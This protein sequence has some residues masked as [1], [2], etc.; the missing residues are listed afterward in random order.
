MSNNNDLTSFSRESLASRMEDYVSQGRKLTTKLHT[1]TLTN[2]D[3]F[4]QTDSVVENIDKNVKKIQKILED[5]NKSFTTSFIQN[6][7]NMPSTINQITPEL[8]S[9]RNLILQMNQIQQLF[10]IPKHMKIWQ[11]KG[12]YEKLIETLQ[13][14]T[15]IVK[16]F[17]E[18]PFIIKLVRECNTIALKLNSSLLLS[19]RNPGRI[20]SSSQ[21]ITHT[22]KV[23]TALWKLNLA[24]DGIIQDA[25]LSGITSSMSA[26]LISLMKIETSRQRDS[27]PT[28]LSSLIASFTSVSI[29]ISSLFQSFSTYMNDSTAQFRALFMNAVLLKDIEKTRNEQ[30]MHSLVSTILQTLNSSSSLVLSSKDKDVE[31]E[32]ER[33][34]NRFFESHPATDPVKIILFYILSSVVLSSFTGHSSFVESNA[35]KN[36]SSNLTPPNPLSSSAS[37]SSSI[38]YIPFDPSRLHFEVPL[39]LP[40]YAALDSSSSSSSSSSNSSSSIFDEVCS[41]LIPSSTTASHSDYLLHTHFNCIFLNPSSSKSF[42]SNKSI[43]L[44]SPSSL[45]QSSHYSLLFGDFAVNR[46]CSEWLLRQERIV[47]KAVAAAN[48]QYGRPSSGANSLSSTTPLSLPISTLFPQKQTIPFLS[49]NAAKAEQLYKEVTMLL[50]EYDL[51]SNKMGFSAT[52]ALN[53]NKDTALTHSTRLPSHFSAN[54]VLQ[55]WQQSQTNQLSNIICAIFAS[56]L[57]YSLRSDMHH[58]TFYQKGLHS[59]LTI[60]F[61]ADCAKY[62]NDYSLYLLNQNSETNTKPAESKN[63]DDNKTQLS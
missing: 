27:N 40:S 8:H 7:S 59:S 42:L 32:L 45:S 60:C 57:P 53:Q 31:K 13:G 28:R 30:N 47:R 22:L 38:D 12:E 41:D 19:L 24:S 20:T 52:Q 49:T 35:Q 17:P 3:L 18:S 6:L 9:T 37:S 62:L 5:T 33:I 36:P 46:I 23:L 51:V 54:D 56:I 63:L 14:L 50:E 11:E 34:L 29:F 2:C 26:S 4:L 16:K 43:D 58:I 61:L 15:Q 55:L 1:L 25:F 44:F 21:Y 39:D 10:M 48:E